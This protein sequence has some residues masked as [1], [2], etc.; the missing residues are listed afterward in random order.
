MTE[1]IIV[2]IV[3]LLLTIV[4]AGLIIYC[5]NHH[6]KDR[7]SIVIGIIAGDAILFL[8]GIVT[9]CLYAGDL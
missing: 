3:L 8:L 7:E 5:S 6:V 9:I 4:S 1:V 2:S